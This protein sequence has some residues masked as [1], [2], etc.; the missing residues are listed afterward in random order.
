MTDED[1]IYMRRALCLAKIAADAG[2]VPVGAVVV[3]DGKIV[4]VGYNLRETAKNALRHAELSA[5]D[6]ACRR[7]GGWR[8]HR[9]TLYVTLEPCV[10]CAGAI[11]NARIKR[12]VYGASDAKAGALGS[13]LDVRSYPLN[14]RPDVEKGVCEAECRALLEQFF[15]RLREKRGRSGR[16]QKDFGSAE[17]DE[18]RDN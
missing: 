13:V 1:I 9:C 18:K 17:S 10:M 6:M 2:E 7:L 4:G 11:V 15:T 16:R 8:L 12:V 5:I 14:H 3:C